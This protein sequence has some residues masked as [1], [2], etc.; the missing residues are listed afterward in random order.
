MKAIWNYL[1]EKNWKRNTKY[2][3]MQLL[4]G[5]VSAAAG[6]V[7]WLFLRKWAFS[8]T[9]WMICFIGYPL[10]LSCVT[11]FLYES[12]HEFHDGSCGTVTLSS[13]KNE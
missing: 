7:L 4:L 12:R 3:L 9:E 13:G 10:I 2:G 8:G 5:T 11:V 1:D 6:F